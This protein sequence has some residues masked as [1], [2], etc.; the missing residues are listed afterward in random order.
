MITKKSSAGYSAEL[1]LVVSE[2]VEDLFIGFRKK[3]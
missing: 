3:V 2:D 1:F